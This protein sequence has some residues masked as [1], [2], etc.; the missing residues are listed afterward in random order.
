MRER[1]KQLRRTSTVSEQRLWNWFRNRSFDGFKFRRQVPIGAY[2]V[3]FYCARLRLAVEVDGQ[4]H[5]TLE[6]S[7]YDSARSLFLQSR[8]IEVVRIT[9]QLLACDSFMAEEVIRD[10]ITR[11]ADELSSQ[12]R[13]LTRPSATLSPP[14]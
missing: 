12:A 6:M 7:D 5:D 4:H 10:A 13:P 9:N 1:A 14:R 2:V 3:D 11:R 8:G